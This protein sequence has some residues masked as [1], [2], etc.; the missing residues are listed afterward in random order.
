MLL[1]KHCLATPKPYCIFPKHCF[2]LVKERNH[3]IGT[4]NFAKIILFLYFN[5]IFLPLHLGLCNP[6][7]NHNSD[8]KKILVISLLL[9]AGI[10]LKAQEQFKYDT[11]IYYP[12][13]VA[14]CPNWTDSFINKNIV[15]HMIQGYIV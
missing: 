8:M 10:S 13:E 9:I 14:G 7:K 15:T 4:K 12:Q 6:N 3:S 1:L 11:L 2:T 5:S